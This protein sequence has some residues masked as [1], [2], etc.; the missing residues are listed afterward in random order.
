MVDADT[1][2]QKIVKTIRRT[3]SLAN[4]MTDMTAEPVSLKD[5]LQRDLKD[6]EF[7]PQEMEN[8]QRLNAD[9]KVHGGMSEV[10]ALIKISLNRL[11]TV[12]YTL[13]SYIRL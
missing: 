4:L 8:L 5:V 7:S 9:I 6:L 2:V 1:K 10:R 12:I 3:L 11:Y 13:F